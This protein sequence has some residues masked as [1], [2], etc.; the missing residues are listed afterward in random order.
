MSPNKATRSGP[1]VVA[2]AFTSHGLVSGK[3]LRSVIV[4]AH[5]NAEFMCLQY[6][7][8]G[9]HPRNI[10]VLLLDRERDQLFS[11]F[12][13]HWSGFDEHDLEI[14]SAFATDIYMKG[15][16][17]GASKL[18]ESLLDTASNA[19]RITDPKPISA[20]DLQAELA[21]LAVKNLCSPLAETEA[22]S[23]VP[24][25]EFQDR[26]RTGANSLV[27]PIALIDKWMAFL[28]PRDIALALASGATV[29]L[30][31]FIGVQVLRDAAH[32]M[33]G[34]SEPSQTV[35][36][37]LSHGQLS[38]I[39]APTVKSEATRV[40]KRA[41]LR[42]RT[43]EGKSCRA[44]RLPDQVRI[45]EPHIAMVVPVELIM[46]SHAPI[47]V[48]KIEYT[49]AP[50]PPLERANGVRRFVQVV[51]SPFRRIVAGLSN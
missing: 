34:R 47:T 19:L 2:A 37:G 39:S 49:L 10:A 14:V 17:M 48:E 18:I 26:G 38:N 6:V 4:T 23:D 27:A 36:I 46:D 28:R 32:S 15:Q 30:I 40:I 29:L 7:C 50:A 5:F 43:G 51:Y 44:F 41:R 13:D 11:R 24:I 42:K 3:N 35:T 12:V 8:S 1:S 16:G 21:H 9:E 45:E 33:T 22:G 20:G 25:V 31:V